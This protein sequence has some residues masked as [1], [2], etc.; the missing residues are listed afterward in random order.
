MQGK[1]VTGRGVG[2]LLF[3]HILCIEMKTEVIEKED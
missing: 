2:Y 3:C 1:E